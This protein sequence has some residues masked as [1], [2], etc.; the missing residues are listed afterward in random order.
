MTSPPEPCPTATP[1]HPTPAARPAAHRGSPWIHLAP[2]ILV[3]GYGASWIALH[4][5]AGRGQV[6]TLLQALALAENAAALL[7]RRRKPTG[8]LLSILAIYLLVDLEPTTLPPLL[9]ALLTVADRGAR[10]RV[11]AATTLTCAV[12]LGMPYLHSEAINPAGY[13]IAH[14][15]AVGVAAA[16]GLDLRNRRVTATPQRGAQPA[17]QHPSSISYPTTTPRS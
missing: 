14:L 5:S 16:I 17:E 12:V 1:T 15:T 13:A 4:A 3:T 11:I 6:H 2:V 7:L 9:L 8:A 10:R